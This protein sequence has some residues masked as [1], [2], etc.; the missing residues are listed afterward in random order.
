M[1]EFARVVGQ[2]SLT[3]PR[4][5]LVRTFSGGSFAR[6]AYAYKS[7]PR[8]YGGNDRVPA[9][10]SRL[11]SAAAQNGASKS[12]PKPL[13]FGMRTQCE[14]MEYWGPIHREALPIGTQAQAGSQ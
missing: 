2:P 12:Q 1:T 6:L 9:L 4:R 8:A 7:I 3:C 14:R 10:D 11:Q 5:V 13:G